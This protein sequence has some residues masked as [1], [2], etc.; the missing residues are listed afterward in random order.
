MRLR[1]HDCFVLRVLRAFL[2]AASLMQADAVTPRPRLPGA[3]SFADAGCLARRAGMY[4]TMPYA[5][6][7]GTVELP[8]VAVQCVLYSVITYFLIHFQISAGAARCHYCPYSVE[9]LPGQGGSTRTVRLP[10]S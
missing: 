7:Q 3:P 2:P 8:Y 1:S 10:S 4:S 5:I 9:C 6:A